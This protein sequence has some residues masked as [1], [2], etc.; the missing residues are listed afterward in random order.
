MCVYIFIAPSTSS[1][2]KIQDA[3]CIAE[4]C[5]KAA[6]SHPEWDNE[7]CSVDC[8]YNHC[9]YVKYLLIF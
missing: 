8:C 7:Y 4:G 5:N 3:M 6:V 9:K 1:D 2:N